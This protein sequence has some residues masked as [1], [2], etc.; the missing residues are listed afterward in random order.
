MGAERLQVNPPIMQGEGDGLG[1]GAGAGLVEDGIDV[2]LYGTL[3][4]PQPVSDFFIGQS[5]CSQ[6]QRLAFARRQGMCGLWLPGCE[7]GCIHQAERFAAGA[8]GQAAEGG[9]RSTGAVIG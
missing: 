4:D 1:A 6:A 9:Y 8:L 5:L 7:L 3:A 2:E